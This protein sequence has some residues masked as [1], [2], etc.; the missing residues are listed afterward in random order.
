MA[1]QITITAE[2][3]GRMQDALRETY[4]RRYEQRPG[5]NQD[6]LQGYGVAL[7]QVLDLIGVD[8]ERWNPMR[9]I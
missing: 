4:E 9:G 5:E 7:S 6:Y 8:H 2:Q 3:I 1:G